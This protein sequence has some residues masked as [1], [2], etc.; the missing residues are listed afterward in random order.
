MSQDGDETRY[1]V[2]AGH[3]YRIDTW[4]D[5]VSAAD[6]L[7]SEGE[8]STDVFV[9]HPG[10]AE[11]VSVFCVALVRLEQAHEAG[12]QRGAQEGARVVLDGALAG[13]KWDAKAWATQL[14]VTLDGS[15]A[16]WRA[17]FVAGF[18]DVVEGGEPG[19]VS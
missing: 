18:V 7:E 11:V 14:A 15:S 12:Y 2:I 16:T 19:G 17:G 1:V 3:T 5:R 9:G 13:G 8:F 10:R 6:A 4:A